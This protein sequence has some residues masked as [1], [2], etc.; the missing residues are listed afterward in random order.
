L[1][2][3]FQI[4]ET[5]TIPVSAN[6]AAE[7]H[8]ELNSP[9]TKTCWQFQGLNFADLE[10]TLI[11]WSQ[12]D[13]LAIKTR[14]KPLKVKAKPITTNGLGFEDALR[15]MLNTPP[16]PSSKPAKKAAAKKNKRPRTTKPL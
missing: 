6:L 4:S 16:P 1:S 9:K 2:T 5:P 7:S 12:I 10:S 11:S 13:W 14:D 3:R 15:K 8:I